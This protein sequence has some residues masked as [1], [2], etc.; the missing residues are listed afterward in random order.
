M[1]H[2]YIL[3][4]TILFQNFLFSQDSQLY[5]EGYFYVST[6]KPLKNLIVT[7]KT[8]GNYDFTDEKGYLMIEAKA[9]DTL[10]Y[11]KKNSRV[12]KLTI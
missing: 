9:G 3:F 4:F 12:V 7:N 11:G 1:K 8:S 2:L 10:L 6:N 5:Y